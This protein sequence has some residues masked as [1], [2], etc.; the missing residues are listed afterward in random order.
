MTWKEQLRRRVCVMWWRIKYSR[1]EKSFNLSSTGIRP[2]HLLLI[3]PPSFDY[4]DVARHMIEPLIEHMQ[5]RFVTLLVPE[6]FRTWLS[7]DLDARVV[8][9]NYRRKNYLGFPEQAFCNK[10]SELETDV[11]VDLMPEFNAYTA[12]LASA[13]Q[14][15][16]RISLSTEQDLHFYNVFIE[17]DTE[18]SLKERYE[19]LLQYV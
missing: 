3:L 7:R 18:K 2:H 10:V 13:S 1:K 15:P 9:Y 8:A 5:P 12:G 17:Y 11:V 16:L 14:A 4:F 6:N 19:T